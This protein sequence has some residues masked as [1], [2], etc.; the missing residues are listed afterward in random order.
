[1]DANAGSL[2][3]SLSAKGERFRI[4]RFESCDSKVALSIDK[5]A[6][7]M[8]ILNRFS[9]LLFYCDSSHF[10]ASGGSRPA[11]LGIVGFAVRNSAPLR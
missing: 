7:R 1:M 10:F 8:A 9:A 2:A 4:V 11:I 3:T 6:I 5:D